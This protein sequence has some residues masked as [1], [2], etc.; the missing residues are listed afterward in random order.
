MKPSRSASRDKILFDTDCIFCNKKG[1]K[2]KSKKG[3]NTAEEPSVFEFGVE[4]KVQ[5]CAEEKKDEKLLTR[6]RGVC[7]FSVEAHYHPSC[8]KEYTRTVGLG[9]SEN[10]ESKKKQLDLERIHGQA[11]ESVCSLIKERVIVQGQILKLG[12]ICRYYIGFAC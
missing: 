6:I 5:E 1:R 8:R 7:L 10:E 12:D 11:F 3:I 4:K 2:W 9:R